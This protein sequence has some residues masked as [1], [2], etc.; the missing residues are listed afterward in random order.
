[1]AELYPPWNAQVVE[2][3]ADV[4]GHTD[5]GMTG[6]QITRLLAELNIPDLQQRDTK[7]VRLRHALLAAQDKDGTAGSVVAFVNRSMEPVRYRDNPSLWTSRQ[8]ALN[9]VLVF[10]GFRVDEAGRVQ[11]GRHA[12]TLSQATQHAS[13]LRAELRRRGTHKD[14][15][16]YCTTELL[17]KNAFHAVLEATK[18][19]FDKLRLR[20]GCC[21]DGAKL[22][23]LTLCPGDDPPLAVN[24]L[25]SHS[26]LDEQ[27]GFANL[28]KGVNSMFR[29]PVAHDPR[30]K[31]TVT[32]E[33]LLELLTMLSMVHR[34]LDTA[35]LRRRPCQSP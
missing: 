14:V 31:R 24:G 32:D 29:N 19:V 11:Q 21:G 5:H 27:K 33:E 28:L 8:A 17:Q 26:E 2:G 10:E 23:E 35:Q 30:L 18:S 15:L 25:S 7:R 12:E 13:N 4:L 16:H 6:S 34:R 22:I 20:T 3:V 1:M 9:E